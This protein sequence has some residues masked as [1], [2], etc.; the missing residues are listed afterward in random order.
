MP[1]RKPYSRTAKKKAP[2]TA[3]AAR[4]SSSDVGAPGPSG[5]PAAPAPPVLPPIPVFPGG[6][7]GPPALPALADFPALPV[8]PVRPAFLDIVNPFM[9]DDGSSPASPVLASPVLAG[10]T[11]RGQKRNAA[12]EVSV[13]VASGAFLMRLQLTP[14]PV[15]KRTAAL[16]PVLSRVVCL[17]CSK[18]IDKASTIKRKGKTIAVGAACV[19]AAN[20]KC[21]YCAVQHHDCEEVGW[22]SHNVAGTHAERQLRFPPSS[23][24]LSTLSS[25]RDLP[26]KTLIM[27]V[28]AL[29]PLVVQGVC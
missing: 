10:D 2:R 24:R 12:E 14:T 22:S 5:P 15:A 23:L 29:A 27:C 28:W 20:R 7:A 26:S 16:P 3:D 17:R 18:R 11:P 6:S 1:L 4:D 13:T 8:P 9:R 19:K 21:E 25:L